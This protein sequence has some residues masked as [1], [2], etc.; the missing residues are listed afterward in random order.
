MQGQLALP[1]RLA[2]LAGPALLARLALPASENQ[3]LVTWSQFGSSDTAT[4]SLSQPGHKTLLPT[5]HRNH[6]PGQGNLRSEWLPSVSIESGCLV[7]TG[8]MQLTSNRGHVIRWH[9]L[10]T[11]HS[12]PV[13]QGRYS[14]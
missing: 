12:T 14:R 2:L 11:G 1:A 5:A 6:S 7:D 13:P 4:F 9:H 8:A 3:S 10:Y